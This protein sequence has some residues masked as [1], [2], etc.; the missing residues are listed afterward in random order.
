MITIVE[1]EKMPS[2][3]PSGYMRQAST[4]EMTVT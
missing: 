3:Y 2:C 4:N 1:K